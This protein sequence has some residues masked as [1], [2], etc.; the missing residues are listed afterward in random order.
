MVLKV[1]GLFAGGEWGCKQKNWNVG[2]NSIPLNDFGFYDQIRELE[3]KPGP[4]TRD[5][6]QEPETEI[7]T[8]DGLQ[9]PI[10]GPGIKDRTWNQKTKEDQ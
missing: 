2:E 8:R 9:D 6:K 5:R 10:P 3:P 7:G 4:G 1:A